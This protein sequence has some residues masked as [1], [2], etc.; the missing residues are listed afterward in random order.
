MGEG[1]GFSMTAKADKNRENPSG[2]EKNNK[3]PFTQPIITYLH[4][5]LM[6]GNLFYRV[7]EKRDTLIQDQA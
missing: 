2:T 1:R 7:S 6:T 5:K 4:I 3:K